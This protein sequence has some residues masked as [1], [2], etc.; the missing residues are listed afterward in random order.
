M[1]RERIKAE[2]YDNMNMMHRYDEK[3]KFYY[4]IIPSL[5][6]TAITIAL[7]A[8]LVFSGFYFL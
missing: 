2:E 1:P 8:A 3:G 5:L 4:R 7:L 6:D